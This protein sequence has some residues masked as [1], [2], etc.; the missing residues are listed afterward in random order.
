[1]RC[2]EKETSRNKWQDFIIYKKN[3][4]IIDF[5]LLKN[6]II[7]L[8]RHEGLNQIII[9]NLITNESHAIQFEEE[10]YD[11]GLLHQYEFNTDWI[12]FSFSSPIT[13]RTIFDYNCLTKEKVLKKIQEIGNKEGM[14]GLASGFTKLDALTSGWQRSASREPLR[15]VAFI[16]RELLWRVFWWCLKQAPR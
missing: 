16:Q 9:Q 10:A 5:I 4:S 13:P 2:H 11:L 1:M 15:Q 6:W 14:S 12:R 3:I 7:Y 8:Q